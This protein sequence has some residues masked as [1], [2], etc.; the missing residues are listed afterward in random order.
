MI[1][2]DAFGADAPT[3]TVPLRSVGP[4]DDRPVV[5]IGGMSNFVT[6]DHK[7]TTDTISIC[8]SSL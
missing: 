8:F 1:V 2:R 4:N 3:V 5:T 6:L 7:T